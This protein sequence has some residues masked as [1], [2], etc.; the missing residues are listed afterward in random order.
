MSAVVTGL[1]I[2]SLRRR[3]PRPGRGLANL[4]RVLSEV[5]RGAG[6]HLPESARRGALVGAA[7]HP[8]GA[9]AMARR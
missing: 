9:A 4:V 8:V 5:D 7:A 1:G 2:G 6:Y 3:P